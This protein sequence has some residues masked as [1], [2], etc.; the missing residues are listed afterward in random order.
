M[1]KLINNLI[2][3]RCYIECE[4]ALF[5]GFKS[6]ECDVIDADDEWIKIRFKDINSTIKTKII[7]IETIKN[8]DLIV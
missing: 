7:R 1:S 6:I 4:D 5:S 8:L 2:G 3:Q